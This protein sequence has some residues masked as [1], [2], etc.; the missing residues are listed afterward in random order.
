MVIWEIV[1]KLI[2]MWR[3]ARNNHVVWFICIAIIN[4]L[5]ILPIVYLSIS[6]KKTAKKK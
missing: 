5:G 4:T 6:K 2:G 3:A 1:W